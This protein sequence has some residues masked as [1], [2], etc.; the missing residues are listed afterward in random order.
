[1]TANVTIEIARRTDVLRVPNAALRFRPT[2]D[3]FAALNQA[4][5]PEMQRGAGGGRMGGPGGTRRPGA[6]RPAASA[7]RCAGAGGA[8]AGAGAPP[9]AQPRVARTRRRQAAGQTPTEPGRAAGTVRT[10]QPRRPGAGRP[11]RLRRRPERGPGRTP[12][13]VPGADGQHVARGTRP[14]RGSGC[15]SAAWTRT[16]P[17][18]AGAADSGRGGRRAAARAPG[19]GRGAQ[20]GASRRTNRAG[21]QTI[22]Q[23][24]GPLPVAETLRPRVARRQRAVEVGAAAAG[25]HRRHLHRTAV[26]RTAARPG[27]GDGGR[28]AGAG[29]CRLHAVAAD[30]GR[31]RRARRAG[32]V[33]AA[34]RR[35]AA[36]AA[37]A[38]P[39]ISVKD[40]RKTYVVGDIQVHALRGVTV[41]VEPGEFVCVT[42]PSG[43]GKSTF[44]HILGL[45]RPADVRPVHPRRP[46][47]LEAVARRSGEGAQPPDRVRLPGLQPAV[48][49]ERHRER[50]TAAALQPG[51]HQGV[52][53]PQARAGGARDRRPRSSGRTTIRTSCRAASSSASRSRGRSSTTRRS[54]SPTSRPATS[55]PGRASR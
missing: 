26:R 8:R 51:P 31:P 24:F 55:T 29:G 3:I 39:V 7:A 28:D 54:C 18:P 5:P 22:D 42:G 9:A 52:G 1:M 23:L 36:E 44:M 46:G 20:R 34:G 11:W 27:T 40:L 10:G 32:R 38:M 50:R 19:A 25:H 53:P 45:P 15:G 2:A 48:A 21:A 41:D 47:R 6:R 30:A 37:K 49:D 13:P 4:V 16:T 17:A 35:S 33:P 12:A 14:V 43:S